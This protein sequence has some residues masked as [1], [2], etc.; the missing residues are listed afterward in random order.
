MP[1]KISNET[2]QQA[3]ELRASG[4][5]YS[6]I[7]DALDVSISWCRHNLVSAQ[8]KT[9]EIVD[10]LES[11]S[12]TKKGVSKGEIAKAVDVDQS[13]E[14]LKKDVQ[15]VT[16]RLR[17]RSKENIVRPNWMVPEFSV[18]ITNS[19][20]QG[21]MD[22][23]QRLHE[24]AYELHRMLL[25]NCTTEEQKESIPSVFA[26]KGA[27]TTLVYTMTNQ[28]GKAGGILENWLE[29]LYNTAVK[30]ENRNT[31][32]EVL[33]RSVPFVLPSELHDLDEVAY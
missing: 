18:F 27:I 5:S 26:L 11:K 24:Q 9:K 14:Q 21:S 25:D 10:G 6:Y 8:E 33:S 20:V 28:S 29:S 13:K 4:K 19:I 12:R 32:N 31:T 3:Q 16:Q 30:L 1:K 22:A 2:L 17:K 23:E 15:K 7:S